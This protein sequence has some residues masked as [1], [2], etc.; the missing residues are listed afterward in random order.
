M[1]CASSIDMNVFEGDSW[2]PLRV[3]FRQNPRDFFWQCA[4][5]GQN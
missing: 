3:F 4:T 5:F 1:M 2:I